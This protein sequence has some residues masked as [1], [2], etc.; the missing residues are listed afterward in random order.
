MHSDH[1]PEAVRVRGDAVTLRVGG[2]YP[3][4]IELVGETIRGAI[5]PQSLLGEFVL[6]EG[7]LDQKG[8]PINDRTRYMRIPVSDPARLRLAHELAS[9]DK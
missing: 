7:R 5:D 2:S 1:D 6:V 8:S 4:E 3:I 9:K